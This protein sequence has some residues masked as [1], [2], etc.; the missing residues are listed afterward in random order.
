MTTQPAIVVTIRPL[1]DA[2]ERLGMTRQEVIDKAA[3]GNVL[4]D[5]TMPEHATIFGIDHLYVPEAWIYQVTDQQFSD[6]DD[7]D[8]GE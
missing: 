1:R 5:A 3:L 6:D 2:V 8:D 7:G 4:I